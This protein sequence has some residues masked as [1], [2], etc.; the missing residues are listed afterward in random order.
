MRA[1]PDPCRYAN[2]T[3]P[4]FE[5]V[6][7]SKLFRRILRNQAGDLGHRRFK[8]G[9]NHS[10]PGLADIAQFIAAAANAKNAALG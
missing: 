6:N 10:H 2:S 5:R 1:F 9:V 4:M 7:S 3:G 8:E